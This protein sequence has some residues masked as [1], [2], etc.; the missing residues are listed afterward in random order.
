MVTS[1]YFYQFDDIL[2][3]FLPK[4]GQGNT[5]SSQLVTAVNKLIDGFYNNGDVY[6]NTCIPFDGLNDLSN[7]ANWLDAHIPECHNI[8]AQIYNIHTEDEYS[9]IL[10][11]LADCCF[12]YNLIRD[13][14][15][16]KEGNIYTCSGPYRYVGYCDYDEYEDTDGDY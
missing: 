2:H 4:W 12:D 8:L 13:Y 16:P 6:D 11:E 7:C 3:E 10:K 9:D 1:D 15:L 5:M 14:N